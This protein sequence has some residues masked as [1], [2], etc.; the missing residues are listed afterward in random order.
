[1]NRLLLY[2]L[3]LKHYATVSFLQFTTTKDLFTL[4]ILQIFL[5]LD[6]KFINLQS[7]NICSPVNKFNSHHSGVTSTCILLWVCTDLQCTI[8]SVS[9]IALALFNWAVMRTC[10]SCPIEIL[11]WTKQQAQCEKRYNVNMASPCASLDKTQH[12][13][14]G[15]RIAT[16]RT[17][18]RQAGEVQ[19]AKE[20]WLQTI[21]Q[22]GS[23]YAIDRLIVW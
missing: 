17:L 22:M 23:V 13:S 10:P 9:V 2:W 21:W 8:A 18:Y 7:A 12:K 15:C 6:C 4:H 20:L 1:M 11:N 19:I 14:F 5:T 3:E 16:Y